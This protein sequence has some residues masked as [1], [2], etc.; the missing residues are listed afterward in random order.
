MKQGS[1]K[2]AHLICYD[3]E[4]QK[5]CEVQLWDGAEVF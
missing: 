3:G 2:P 1:L 5:Q 4:Y